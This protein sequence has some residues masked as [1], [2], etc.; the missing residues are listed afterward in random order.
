MKNEVVQIEKYL[1]NI[2]EQQLSAKLFNDAYIQYRNTGNEYYL[3]D[4]R[5]SIASFMDIR[6]KVQINI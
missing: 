6:Q 1:E 4:P 5:L 2:K 3:G